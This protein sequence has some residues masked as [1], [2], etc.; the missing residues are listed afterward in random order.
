MKNSLSLWERALYHSKGLTAAAVLLLASTGCINFKKDIK[1]CE[2]P[3]T[4][5]E[6]AAPFLWEI[7]RNHFILPVGQDPDSKINNF[8]TG[9]KRAESFRILNPN[10]VHDETALAQIVECNIGLCYMKK[11]RFKEAED[12]LEEFKQKYPQSTSLPRLEQGEKFKESIKELRKGYGDIEQE[13][14]ANAKRLALRSNSNIFKNLGPNPTDEELFKEYNR[15]TEYS[16]ARQKINLDS[17]KFIDNVID[18]YEQHLLD[19][20]KPF[21]G[22]TYEDESKDLAVE[23]LLRFAEDLYKNDS[24]FNQALGI[25]EGIIKG[26]EFAKSRKVDDAQF[27]KAELFESMAQLYKD[28]KLDVVINKGENGKVKFKSRISR[29][30][31]FNR[32]TYRGLMNFAMMEY[33]EL[34]HHAHIGSDCW[35][36][37][38]GKIKYLTELAKKEDNRIR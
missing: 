28:N 14:L 4:Y 27:M 25:F 17:R 19:S 21:E 1:T 34:R 24:K 29:G 15:L 22:T 38:G 10:S 31:D 13:I 32:Q 26:K 9:L 20:S 33:E 36:L 12:S 2:I 7:G 23:S 30:Y 37:S 5:V 6:V 3:Q 16:K 35:R 18:S 8:E 11:S